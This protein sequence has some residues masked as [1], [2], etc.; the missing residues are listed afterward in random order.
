MD[1]VLENEYISVIISTLG[2]EIQSIKKDGKEM[3][4]Q[5]KPGFWSR[6]APVLFPVCG[7]L[8]NDEF[9]YDGKKY[10]L[11]KH[12]YARD[13]EF[14]LESHDRNKAVFLHKSDQQTIK[15]F[16]FEYELRIIYTLEKSKLNIE[17]NIKN[18]LEKTMYCSI[19]AHE[20]YC[21]PG[22]IEKYSIKFEQQEDLNSLKLKDALLS[23]ETFSVGKNT[24][25]IKLSYKYFVPEIDTLVFSHLKSK[26]AW[27][28]NN[29]TDERI[30]IEYQGFDYLGIWTVKDAE[31]IC[32]E[33]WCGIPDFADTDGDITKK[34][35]ILKIPPK[36]RVIKKHSILF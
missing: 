12:G 1:I 4:W 25:E 36:E 16:P 18:L 29:E 33:P 30:E 32:F 34:K 13:T 24:N 3:I 27:I 21:C 28:K 22:G 17:Y 11:T 2:A 19:G 15:V 6:H 31:Y 10:H 14:L 26:K 8:K 35:G 23:N 20:A 9:V 7:G 5:G